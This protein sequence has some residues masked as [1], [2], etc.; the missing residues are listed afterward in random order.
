M[1]RTAWWRGWTCRA[2]GTSSSS[3]SGRE[4]TVRLLRP[5][6]RQTSGDQSGRLDPRLCWSCAGDDACPGIGPDG[7]FLTGVLG[8]V[9]CQAQTIG[10]GGYQALAAPGSMIWLALTGVLT[11]F[12][13]LFGYRM[14]L[15]QVLTVRESVVAVAK[16]GVV[17]LLATSWP[18]FRT[19]AYD[20]AMHGPAELAA[21]MGGSSYLPG[22]G[23]RMVAGLQQIDDGLIELMILGTG[24]PP[25]ADEIVGPTQPLTPVQQQQQLQ[26]LKQLQER[27]TWDPGREA[28]MV[29]EGRT[30]YLASVLAAFAA[31]RTVAGLLLAL[32]PFFALFLL[33]DMTRG[34]FVGWVRGLVGAFLAAVATTIIFGI[35]IALVRPWLAG[36]LIERR[37]GIAT[38]SAPIE[39]LV[40][41]LV[42]ALTLLA[43][44]IASAR[45]AQGLT[46]PAAIRAAPDQIVEA[47]R[48]HDLMQAVGQPTLTNP[49][50]Q[51]SRALG[52]ADAV[53][54]ARIR[55][56][57]G[58]S[59]GALAGG[60][61]MTPTGNGFAG[62]STTVVAGGAN[63]TPGRRT[64]RRV[65]AQAGR[66]DGQP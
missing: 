36:V 40:L 35:E 39:L 23:G 44:L 26:H 41:S 59:F 50:G 11:I 22:S 45:V 60:Q 27:P 30:V 10:Q 37:A 53:S 62:R 51:R 19:V 9:D 65:S 17:L 55:E 14:I 57:P 61:G 18:A 38:P 6:I 28:A 5:E 48:R 34:L 21:S 66:R 42:F 64:R 31:V 16:I 33:F 25:N 7:P 58:S 13:A 43:A 49:A 46:V 24:K 8:Y 12:V 3:L 2:N 54:A 15:G 29:G 1:A 52:I 20:V 47:L 56:A 63:Y 32:A 4:R